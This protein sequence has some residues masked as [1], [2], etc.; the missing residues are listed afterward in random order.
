MPKEKYGERQ[1]VKCRAGTE[2]MKH[3]WALQKKKKETEIRV[4]ISVSHKRTKGIDS[5]MNQFMAQLAIVPA[6]GVQ[7]VE[8]LTVHSSMAHISKKRKLVLQFKHTD[9]DC[10]C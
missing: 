7:G 3:V 2:R 6:W 5:K 8:P 10:V 9:R 4:T 1:V